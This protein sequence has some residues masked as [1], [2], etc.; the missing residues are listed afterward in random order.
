MGTSQ[1]KGVFFGV[2]FLASGETPLI[3]YESAIQNYIYLVEELP[4]AG[5]FLH[6]RN[7]SKKFE[8][9][10]QLFYFLVAIS[11]KK[12]DAYYVVYFSFVRIIFLMRRRK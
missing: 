8:D 6:F 4:F 5:F 7:T 11:Q 10:L 9:Q 2:S 3:V 12:I 1:S